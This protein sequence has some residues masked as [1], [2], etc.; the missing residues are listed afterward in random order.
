[1]NSLVS[2]FPATFPK[3]LAGLIVF[4]VLFIGV[5]IGVGFLLGRNRLVNVVMSVYVALVFTSASVDVLPKDFPLTQA[6]LFVLLLV[7]LTLV[8]RLLFEVHVP[9]LPQDTLW[10]VVV[11][12]IIVTGMIVS[13]LVK[14]VP[15]KAVATF[16]IS[17]PIE[18]FGTPLAGIIWLA[19]PLLAL[20]FL[21]RRS[22]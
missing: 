2:L 22:K 13:V 12:G 15:K 10:R 16:P 1:M 11:T 3:D 6:W 21:N 8:D 18:Y 5:G 4:G 7:L 20:F 9:S 14:L 19:V 17:V